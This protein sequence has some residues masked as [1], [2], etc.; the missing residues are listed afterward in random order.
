MSLIQIHIMF[1]SYN[2]DTDESEL[3]IARLS[4][5]M[6]LLIHIDIDKSKLSI[7][8]LSRIVFLLIHIDIDESKLSITRLSHIMFLLLHIDI[9]ECN[10]SPCQNSGTCSDD[11]NQYTC[12]CIPGYAGTNCEI[13]I[14]Y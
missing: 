13:G 5:T 7:S 10:S 2:L 4:H 11:V 1:F 12:S 8:R 9:D 3:T 6:F 14:S